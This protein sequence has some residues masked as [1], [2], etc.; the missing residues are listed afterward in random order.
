MDLAPM[1]NRFFAVRTKSLQNRPFR[2]AAAVDR[3]EKI[4]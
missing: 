3:D 4:E 1:V 2:P